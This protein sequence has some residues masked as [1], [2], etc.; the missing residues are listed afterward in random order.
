MP[1]GCSTDAVRR[2]LAPLRSML[3]ADGY[4]LDATVADGDV[5][6]IVAAGRDACPTCLVP[7]PLVAS[8]ILERLRAADIAVEPTDI[9]LDYPST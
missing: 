7:G 4:L 8:M 2:A 9:T 5:R 1:V 6:V 3:K